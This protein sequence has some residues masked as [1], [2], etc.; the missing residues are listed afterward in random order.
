MARN[1]ARQNGERIT[2]FT[3]AVFD[4]RSLDKNKINEAPEKSDPRYY[5]R[6]WKTILARTVADGGK[7][8]Y[9]QG[10]HRLTLP[11]L[12]RKVWELEVLQ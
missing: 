3:T 7:S 4:L 6:P 9:V 8:Y 2:D 1:V 10:E 5:F 12:A 11:H